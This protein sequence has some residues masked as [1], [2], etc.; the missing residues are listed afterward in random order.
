MFAWD[1]PDG[2]RLYPASDAAFE[3]AAPYRSGLYRVGEDIPAGTY[4]VTIEPEAAAEADNECG[5][6]VMRDLAFG[7]GSITDEKY[8]VRG[9]SQTVTVKDGDWLELYAATAVPAQ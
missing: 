4:T 9:G 3:P 1:A 8:V 7:S 2:L 5:A 6:F